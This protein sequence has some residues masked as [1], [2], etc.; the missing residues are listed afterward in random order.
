MSD[1]DD[2]QEDEYMNIEEELNDLSELINEIKTMIKTTNRND[3]PTFT[4]LEVSILKY[5]NQLENI[6]NNNNANSENKKAAKRLQSELDNMT[7]LI[8][9]K[10]ANRDDSGNG[11]RKRTRRKKIKANKSKRKHK[12]KKR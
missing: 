4:S 12:S 1:T 7:N 2:E 10:R 9:L 3:A 8:A 5:Q 6:I 11:K